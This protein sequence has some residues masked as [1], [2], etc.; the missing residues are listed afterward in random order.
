MNGT[1]IDIIKVGKLITFL[2]QEKKLSQRQLAEKLNVTRQ[3]ISKWENG[4]RLPSPEM[5]IA[6]SEFFE[7][8]INEILKG[9]RV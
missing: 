7:V 2:R 3:A 4:L 5:L 1:Y 6:L 8:S 9:K